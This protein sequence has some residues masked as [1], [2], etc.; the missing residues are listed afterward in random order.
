MHEQAVQQVDGRAAKGIAE[1]VDFLVVTG[2]SP[3]FEDTLICAAVAGM[4]VAF[5]VSLAVVDGAADQVG[6]EVAD[7]VPDR[8]EGAKARV[9][10]L[11]ASGAHRL[12]EVSAETAKI[13]VD[14]VDVVVRALIDP[15]Q[16]VDQYRR[17]IVF[18]HSYSSLETK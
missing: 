15:E 13:P 5:R 16:T 8:S 17:V 9:V 1:D 4:S 7:A 2:R 10:K 18:A 11:I 3:V 6:I 14:E 12:G